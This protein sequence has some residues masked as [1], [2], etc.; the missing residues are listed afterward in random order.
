M[1]LAF[2]STSYFRSA[3]GAEKIVNVILRNMDN[4]DYTLF[5]IGNQER[6]CPCNNPIFLP[7][8]E[9]VRIYQNTFP[10]PL[11]SKQ[12][13]LAFIRDIFLYFKAS[14]QFAFFL[15]H[16]AIQAIH[17]HLVNID[18]L[19]LVFYKF[20]F[21]YKL[22]LTFTGTELDLAKSSSLSRFKL[23]LA[24]KHAER[25]TVVS[26]EI[27][28]RLKQE[29]GFHQAIYIPN[30]IETRLPEIRWPVETI[31]DMKKDAFVFCGR[32]HAV[33]RI[34]FLIEAFIACLD[35]GL[36]NYL[37]IVGDGEERAYLEALI[38]EYRLTDR[39][40]ITGSMKHEKVLEVMRNCKALLLSSESEGCPLVVLEAMALGKAVVAPAVGGLTDIITH[41]FNGL[42][43]PKDR[44]DLLTVAILDLEHSPDMVRQ[45]GLEAT[46]TIKK[47]FP[48][49]RMMKQYKEI[50]FELFLL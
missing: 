50:Y 32:L 21:R 30:G 7:L 42:L 8:P 47:N 18:V 44:K 20:F 43:F 24:L 13:P 11:L 37:Y 40:F 10:N 4:P 34:P 1:R 41:R 16:N 33:K 46:Q 31:A 9:S 22:I 29:Y 5:L 36:D 26:K 45:L 27:G 25:V 39:V 15:R 3:G 19:L 48:L 6:G 2:W 49:N 17:L 28:D 14:I 23:K 35:Q 38:L 12:R